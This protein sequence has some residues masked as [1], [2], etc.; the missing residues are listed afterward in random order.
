[1]EDENKLRD[2]W[3]LRYFND[4]ELRDKELVSLREQ[5]SDSEENANIYSIEAEEMR[6]E[7]KK[8]L[9]EINSAPKVIQPVEKEKEKPDYLE[10]LRIAQSSLLEH[11]EKINQL[12]ENIDAFKETEEKQREMMRKNEELSS[13]ILELQFKIAERDKEINNIRQKEHLTKEMTSMLDNAYSEFNVLQ[14]KMQKL[15]SQ[16]SSSKMINLEYED[17]KESYRKLS[18]DFEEQKM[19]LSS[20]TSDNQ[21]LQSQLMET[22]EKLREATFHRQQ[23]QKRVTYLEELNSDLQSV[24][25]ANKKLEGQLKRIGELESMLSM[26]AEE[27]DQMIRRRTEK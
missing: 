5:L 18:R 16:V 3:K 1:K 17:L 7:N 19:K 8:L 15:E 20:I 12:L 27:R 13:Q 14:S 21:Q 6:K 10:Q 9:A 26:A 24:S 25:D 2:E 11:N 4:I 22:E 23:M